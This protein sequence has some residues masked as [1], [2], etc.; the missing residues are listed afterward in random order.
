[1]YGSGYFYQVHLVPSSCQAPWIE[2]CNVPAQWFAGVDEIWLGQPKSRGQQDVNMC[3]Y[4]HGVL[5][6]HDIVYLLVLLL[7]EQRIIFDVEPVFRSMIWEGLKFEIMSCFPVL[8]LALLLCWTRKWSSHWV[9]LVMLGLVASP[10]QIV[11]GWW[12]WQPCLLLWLVWHDLHQRCLSS[13][14]RHDVVL[15]LW[16]LGHQDSSRLCPILIES[17]IQL[18]RWC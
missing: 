5:C 11:P 2:F 12:R 14:K 6:W 10:G 17:A 13:S 15:G 1:M 9:F 8:W 4:D 18:K 3:P 7:P 16:S